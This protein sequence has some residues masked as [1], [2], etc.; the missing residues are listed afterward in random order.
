MGRDEGRIFMVIVYNSLHIYDFVVLPRVFFLF[1]RYHAVGIH[2]FA[3]GCNDQ[4][5]FGG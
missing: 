3:G 2:G 4:M 1:F 5:E